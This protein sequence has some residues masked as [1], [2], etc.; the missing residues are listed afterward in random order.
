[1]SQDFA[2]NLDDDFHIGDVVEIGHPRID[3]KSLTANNDP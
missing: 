1:M 3:L 2:R